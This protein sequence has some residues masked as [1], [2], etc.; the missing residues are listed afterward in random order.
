[1]E[2]LSAIDAESARIDTEHAGYHENTAVNKLF[3]KQSLHIQL[4]IYL[5]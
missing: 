2:A 1:M 4:K 5:Y 3:H